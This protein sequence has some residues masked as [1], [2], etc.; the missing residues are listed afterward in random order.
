MRNANQAYAALE[1]R[2]VEWARSEDG[3]RAAVVIGSRA[4]TDHPADA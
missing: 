3:I 4:R 1:A 2:F